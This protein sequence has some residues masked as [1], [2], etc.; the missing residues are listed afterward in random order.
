MSVRSVHITFVFDEGRLPESTIKERLNA[1]LDEHFLDCD[2]VHVHWPEASSEAPLSRIAQMAEQDSKVT[3]LNRIMRLSDQLI[4]VDNLSA[5]L[6]TYIEEA[7]G[8][9]EADAGTLAEEIRQATKQLTSIQ[10]EAFIKSQ[11][12]ELID[13]LQELA[14]EGAR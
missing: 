4:R 3:V 1:L 8:A 9:R 7:G 5:M 10:N 13:A 6:L 14:S 11:L 12:N 2:E